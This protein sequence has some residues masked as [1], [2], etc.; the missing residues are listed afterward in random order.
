MPRK[1][2]NGNEANIAPNKEL[3][4]DISDTAV[5]ITAEIKVL[6]IK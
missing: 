1:E 6:V 4:L 5:I 2:T 3:L